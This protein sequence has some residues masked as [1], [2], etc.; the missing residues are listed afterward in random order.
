MQEYSQAGCEVVGVEVDSELV[1]RHR[2]AGLEVLEGYAESLP[3]ADG[4]FDRIVCSVVVPYSD[5]RRAVAEWGRVLKPGGRVLAT[6]HG[7][8]Y[9]WN[10]LLNGDSLLRRM[11]G[12]RML[13]NTL[14]YRVLGRRLPGFLGDTLCQGPQRLGAY[15]RR[16]GL[17]VESQLVVDRCCGLPRF[18]GMAARRA[19]VGHERTAPG[20]ARLRVAALTE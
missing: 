15:L 10:Y 4:S 20:P 11:Y 19:G 3:F 8:G 7:T 18:F 9:G 2:D 13:L 16:S 6:F 17:T 5:E 14:S 12:A 1:R